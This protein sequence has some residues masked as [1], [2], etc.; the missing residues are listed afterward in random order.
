MISR[1]SELDREADQ[2]VLPH[3]TELMLQLALKQETALTSGRLLYKMLR[4]LIDAPEITRPQLEE[5]LAGLPNI[6]IPELLP[7]MIDR[8]F[9]DEPG[10]LK[11]KNLIEADEARRHEFTQH[12]FESLIDSE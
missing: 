8:V 6:T 11:I 10:L 2:D 7:T 1:F 5:Q 12:L 3:L 9:R 4:I